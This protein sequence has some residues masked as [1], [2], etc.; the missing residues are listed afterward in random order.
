MGPASPPLFAAEA[1]LHEDELLAFAENI[2]TGRGHFG[3][4]LHEVRLRGRR[5]RGCKR[6][7]G[8]R[9]HHGRATASSGRRSGRRGG[10]GT[11]EAPAL[12]ERRACGAAGRR[13][14]ACCGST[15]RAARRLRRGRGGARVTSARAP[16]RGRR[17]RDRRASRSR[18]LPIVIHSTHKITLKL[19]RTIFIN[20]LRLQRLLRA[21]IKFY[22][23]LFFII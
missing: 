20:H 19:L 23:A 22:S 15:W 4:L 17:L 13:L 8:G 7:S 2:A 5:L 6:L 14:G 1:E 3:E 12:S 10:R 11:C 18:L 21:T 9:G 16:D